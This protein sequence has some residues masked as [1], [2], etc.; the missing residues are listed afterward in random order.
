MHF[1][2]GSDV[3]IEPCFHRLQDLQR[4]S[5]LGQR[6]LL[7]H[8]IQALLTG[9]SEREGLKQPALDLVSRFVSEA[10]KLTQGLQ[11]VL[12]VAR[13]FGCFRQQLE[14][15]SGEAFFPFFPQPTPH[16][17]ELLSGDGRP[18]EGFKHKLLDAIPVSNLEGLFERRR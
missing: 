8:P 7:E 6:V 11:G 13:F 3:V 10:D 18:V 9:A 2:D 5:A 4:F 17:H 14:Q 16:L 12:T 15:G 1:D